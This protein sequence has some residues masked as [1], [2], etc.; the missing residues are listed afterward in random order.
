[1]KFYNETKA[2]YLE[3]DA[4]GVGLGANILQTRSG[5]SCPKDMALDNNILWP[6]TLTSKSIQYRQE[7]QQYRKGCIR[8]ITWPRKIPSLLLCKRG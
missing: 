4:S 8:H 2:L 5:T 6:I 7:I 1:M 3:R